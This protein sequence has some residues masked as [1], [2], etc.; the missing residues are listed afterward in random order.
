[1]TDPNDLNLA[2]AAGTLAAVAGDARES[3]P[4]GTGELRA[5][6]L[7]AYDADAGEPLLK[8]FPA[9]GPL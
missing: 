8:V 6:W 9:G 4:W 1:M 5:A 7:A 3:C 2:R